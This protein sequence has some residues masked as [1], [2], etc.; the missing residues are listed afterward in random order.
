MLELIGSD[1]RLEPPKQGFPENFW[2]YGEV[3]DEYPIDTMR[4]KN[5]LSWP[6]RRAAGAGTCRRAKASGWRCTARSSPMWR[7]ASG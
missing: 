5:V 7:P 1:R 3:Y 2:D 6:P 4:L